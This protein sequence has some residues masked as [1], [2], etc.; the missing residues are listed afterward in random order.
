MNEIK[1]MQKLAGLLI[2]SDLVEYKSKGFEIYWGGSDNPMWETFSSAQKAI[3]YG[4]KNI[5]P[6]D[7]NFSYF[8]V[9]NSKGDVVYKS[10]QKT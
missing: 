4:E 6:E 10:K 1:R 8:V 3:N 9:R 2:E 7:E 5:D